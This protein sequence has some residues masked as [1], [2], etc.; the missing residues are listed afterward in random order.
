MMANKEATGLDWLRLARG[1]GGVGSAFVVNGEDS[2]PRNLEERTVI[3][4]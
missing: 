4:H 1:V 3:I 2:K